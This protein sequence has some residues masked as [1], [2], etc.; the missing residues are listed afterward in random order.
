M[1]PSNFN[2]VDSW[3]TL[4]G[5]RML[6]HH[7]AYRPSR[8]PSDYGDL[9]GLSDYFVTS[10]GEVFEASPLSG[11]PGWRHATVYYVAKTRKR[12]PDGIAIFDKARADQLS[13]LIIG[14]YSSLE[15]AIK[16]ADAALASR[17]ASTLP[18]TTPTAPKFVAAT[19]QELIAAQQAA[20]A[21]R[22]AAATG[23]APATG[24]EPPKKKKPPPKRRKKI[25]TWAWVAGGVG[26]AV[27][28]LGGTAF[29]V[30]RRR[31]ALTGA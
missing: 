8:R 6:G 25:P 26:L 7:I 21:A 31:R 11:L 12:Y 14:S 18:T 5:G 22:L 24:G 2:Y 16:R 30:S 9:G 4:L 19:G 29:V 10:T 13:A 3:Q 23:T 27:L 15:D 28:L 1:R 17:Q 20:E